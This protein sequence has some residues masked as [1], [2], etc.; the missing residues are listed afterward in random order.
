MQVGGLHYNPNNT[1]RINFTKI[2]TKDSTDSISMQ[3]FP[4]YNAGDWS[5]SAYD[6]V[7]PWDSLP[8]PIYG[9]DGSI[10]IATI[11]PD[12]RRH[13]TRSYLQLRTPN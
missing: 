10:K 13:I 7:F 4:G 12:N 1:S 11:D 3:N 9:T 2:T 5:F 6:Y 8:G